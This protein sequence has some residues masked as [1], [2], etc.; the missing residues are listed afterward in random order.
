MAFFQ[1]TQ[2]GLH[3]L[4]DTDIAN[5]GEA[6]LPAGSVSIT[7]AQAAAI[8]NPPLTLAQAQAAQTSALYAAC[9]AAIAS[10]FQSNALGTASG[11]PSTLTDQANQNAVASSASGGALWCQAGG[12]WSMKPHTQAQAQAVIA[13]FVTWL[14]ACQQQLAALTAQVSAATT[15]A[16]AQSVNWVAPA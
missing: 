13:S 7:D 8:Q 5:G 9:Q 1:D 6:F 16:A 4:S 12:A 2:G 11:Y 15:A 10:G 14:N 3:Y